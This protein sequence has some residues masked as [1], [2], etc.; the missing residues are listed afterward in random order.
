MGITF[1]L[2]DLLKEEEEPQAE[3]PLQELPTFKLGDLLAEPAQPDLDWEF[4][5]AEGQRRIEEQPFPARKPPALPPSTMALYPGGPRAP[6][7]PEPAKEGLLLDTA[8]A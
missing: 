8:L 5:Q 1:R 4:E 6:V 2:S 7:V 3:P